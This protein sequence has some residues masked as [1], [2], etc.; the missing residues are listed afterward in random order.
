MR[1]RNSSRIR[2]TRSSSC[3]RNEEVEDEY[4]EVEDKEED[5]DEEED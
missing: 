5:K 1:R 2:R 4:E 3:K